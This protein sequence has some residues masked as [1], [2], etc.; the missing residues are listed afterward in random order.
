MVIGPRDIPAVNSMLFNQYARAKIKGGKPDKA[1]KKMK[2]I[3]GRFAIQ[4]ESRAPVPDNSNQPE[5]KR[6]II[7]SLPPNKVMNSL[8][9]MIWVI[10]LLNPRIRSPNLF[11]FLNT[12][13][14]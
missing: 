4:P 5:R 6:P 13:S 11:V 8:S 9:R 3:K 12:F 10:I 1:K 2:I 7:N 14:F